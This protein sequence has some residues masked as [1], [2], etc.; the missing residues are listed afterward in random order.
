MSSREVNI[1]QASDSFGS[2]AK[3]RGLDLG[4]EFRQSRREVGVKTRDQGK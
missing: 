1:K 4:L 2:A 3:S